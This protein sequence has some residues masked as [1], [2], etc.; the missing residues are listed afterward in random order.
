MLPQKI[1]REAMEITD[2][3]KSVF[4]ETANVLEGSDRRVFMARVVKA[5]GK[6]GQRYVEEELGWNRVTIC[7][8][9][10]ELESGFR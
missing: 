7:K 10:R 8:G 3:F 2:G 4:T 6:G 5:L 1:G 9:T